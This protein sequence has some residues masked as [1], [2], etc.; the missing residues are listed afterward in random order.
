MLRKFTIVSA[1]IAAIAAGMAVTEA[2]AKGGHGGGHGGHGGFHGHFGGPVF[3]PE[4]GWGY[5]AYDDGYDCH[6]FR[7]VP[8]PYGWRWLRVW[9]CN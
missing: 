1:A 5:F 4:Y 3:A 7:R 8:T 9:V 2:V 6:Q